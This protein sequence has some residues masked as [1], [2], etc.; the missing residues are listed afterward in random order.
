MIP[1]KFLRT[2][3]Q[4]LKQVPTHLP[5][6]P[7]FT[8]VLRYGPIK[9]SSWGFLDVWKPLYRIWHLFWSWVRSVEDSVCTRNMGRASLDLFP[10]V[11]GEELGVT[12]SP[13]DR[14]LDLV[15][16]TLPI[17]TSTAMF[18]LFTQDLGHLPQS[19]RC[20]CV[21]SRQPQHAKVPLQSIPSW[22]TQRLSQIPSHC[23]A[24]FLAD[25][26]NPFRLSDQGSQGGGHFLKSKFFK[27][28]NQSQ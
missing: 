16:P 28:G 4:C 11:H 25:G 23:P 17:V 8:L 14:A 20:P 24:W 10:A 13:P 3:P 18:D 2:F 27:E 9:V 12:E 26:H 15:F 7:A 21:C 22:R 6:T 5:P 1:G 19:C